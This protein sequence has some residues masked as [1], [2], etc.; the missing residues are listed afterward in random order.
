[1]TKMMQDKPKVLFVCTGNSCRSQM[2]EGLLKHFGNGE[3][4]VY[5]AGLRPSYVHPLAIKAVA[6]LVIDIT[7][8]YSKTVNEFI[9][10]DF[11][12]VITVCDGAKEFCPVFPGKYKALHWS[13]EDPASIS[14][15]EEEMMKVFRKALQ[16]ILENV[17]HFITT[18]K[19][20]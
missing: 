8:Q 9:G 6:E 15:T 18:N 2:A 11:S 4:E 5:S 1:M 12:Y 20:G 14:G 3:F 16:N 13:I 7:K 10:Q 17:K 19:A